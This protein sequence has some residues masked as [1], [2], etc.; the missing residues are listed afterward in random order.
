MA[1]DPVEKRCRFVSFVSHSRGRGR[2]RAPREVNLLL[3]DNKYAYQVKGGEMVRK[4]S[5]SL[6]ADVIALEI[7]SDVVEHSER[8]VALLLERA[9]ANSRRRPK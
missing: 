2:R 9:I 4:K 8:S 3:I 5:G 7:L 6:G 1:N